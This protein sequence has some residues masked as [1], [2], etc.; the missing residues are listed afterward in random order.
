M[1]K[2]LKTRIQALKRKVKG[3]S[4]LTWS[5]TDSIYTGT[6]PCKSQPR[7]K[8][9]LKSLKTSLLI[10]HPQKSTNRSCL[11]RKTFLI[12]LEMMTIWSLL[13][14]SNKQSMKTWELHLVL[15]PEP[16]SQIIMMPQLTCKKFLHLLQ[17]LHPSKLKRHFLDMSQA[18][19]V[20]TIPLKLYIHQNSKHQPWFHQSILQIRQW[21]RVAVRTP[22]A[23]QAQI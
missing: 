9:I 8:T 3:E 15:E 13:Q 21:R 20:E 16:I 5:K 6:K 19:R 14:H 23:N 10:C 7:W 4:L 2:Q 1:K 18:N 22:W 11:R 17:N 12:L